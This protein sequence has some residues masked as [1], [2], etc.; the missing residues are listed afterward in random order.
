MNPI[1]ALQNALDGL[2]ELN[3][4]RAAL[5]GIRDELATIFTELSLT[6]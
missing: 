1:T 3:D 6:V 5:I 4:V 2:K